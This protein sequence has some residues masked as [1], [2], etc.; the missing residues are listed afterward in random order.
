MAE[1]GIFITAKDLA[2][3]TLKGIGTTGKASL[4]AVRSAA[5][6]A[7]SAFSALGG[8]VT[9][10]NQA[11]EIGKK[12]WEIGRRAM[13]MT[14]GVAL[15]F[16]KAGDPVLTWFEKMRRE[17]ELVG[18]RLGDTLIPVIQGLAEGFGLVGDAASEWVKENRKLIATKIL[19]YILNIGEVLIKSVAKGTLFV[20]KVWKGWQEVILLVTGVAEK[21]FA[22]MITGVQKTLETFAELA[23]MIGADGMA[24]NLKEASESAELLADT[25]STAGDESFEALEKVVAEQEELEN[26]INNTAEVALTKLKNAGVTAFKAIENSVAGVN[27]TIDEQKTLAQRHED[28]LKNLRDKRLRSI[29]AAADAELAIA[30]AKDQRLQ[31]DQAEIASA[32]QAANDIVVGLIETVAAEQAE[33]SRLMQEAQQAAAEGASDAQEKMNAAREAQGQVAGKAAKQ[34]TIAVIDAVSAQ[35]SAMAIQAAAGAFASMS[36][37]PVVGPA[38]GAAAAVA[39]S[40]SVMAIGAGLKGLIAGMADGGVVTGGTAGHD[41]VP[42]MLMPGEQVMSVHERRA[43]QKFMGRLLGVQAGQTAGGSAD[44]FS[45]QVGRPTVVV[46]QQTQLRTWAPQITEEMRMARQLETRSRKKLAQQGML[47][48]QGDVSGALA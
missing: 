31:Q 40:A 9:A 45:A 26:A 30:K 34:T 46:N 13:E 43:M 38:L 32:A 24:A 7:S 21:M 19:N 6:K 37:I 25:F 1:V 44:G 11:M 12:A 8:A 5:Q 4:S 18:A 48:G 33:A 23:S 39:A 14:V 22:G 17:S 47:M 27:K 3:K 10:V 42:A 35:V 15:K 29:Q 16:R 36:S 41:S 28:F 20:V 2:T